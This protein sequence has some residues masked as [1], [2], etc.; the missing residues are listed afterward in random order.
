MKPIGKAA[1]HKHL[2]GKE[3]TKSEAILAKC[4]ECS[5]EY[6]DGL[7][8]CGIVECPL[9]PF[10]PYKGSAK[11]VQGSDY[12]EKEF[13]TINPDFGALTDATEAVIA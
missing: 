12:S 10:M 7:N 2:Q 5:A 6:A 9:Y 1:L 13:C 4:C 11:S 8:D 3:L